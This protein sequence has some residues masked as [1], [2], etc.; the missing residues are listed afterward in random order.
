MD[1][2]G[3]IL[4]SRHG[5]WESIAFL[6]LALCQL[7]V[8]LSV[9][10]LEA[11]YVT[12]VAAQPFSFDTLGSWMLI[13]LFFLSSKST[14]ISPHTLVSVS[15]VPAFNGRM[16]PVILVSVEVLSRCHL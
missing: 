10:S 13:F 16:R 3:S 4:A 9:S 15:E 5:D 12:G 11:L 2:Q 7:S 6:P 14:G 8:S 1:H